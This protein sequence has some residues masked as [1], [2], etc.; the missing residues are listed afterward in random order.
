VAADFA[1][2]LAAAERDAGEADGYAH[3]LEL[4]DGRA[5]RELLP[6]DGDY[7]TPW[8]PEA[9][10][11]HHRFVR[12][13]WTRQQADDFD[14]LRVA[15]WDVLDLLAEVGVGAFLAQLDALDDDGDETADAATTPVD[16]RVPRFVHALAHNLTP[17]D[18]ARLLERRG[19]G[20]RG[21]GFDWRLYTMAAQTWRE[22]R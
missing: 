10:G 18:R 17:C 14:A 8:P 4:E 16:P 7:W 2:R 9:D 19:L 1:K 3:H 12:E 6:A 13:H 15:W 20:V 11:H 5:A 22:S 21:E